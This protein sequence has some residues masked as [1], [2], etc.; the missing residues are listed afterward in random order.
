VANY[1]KA[2]GWRPGLSKKSQ[3]KVVLTYNNSKPYAKT[4]LG[5]A[6]RLR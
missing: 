4:V 3:I 5:L 1:L 6:E 2:H